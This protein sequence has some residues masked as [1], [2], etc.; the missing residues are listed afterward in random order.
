MTHNDEGGEDGEGRCTKYA[1]LDDELQVA[2]SEKT[3]IRMHSVSHRETDAILSCQR[4]AAVAV[5]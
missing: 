3:T 4:G 1:R 2:V 5:W